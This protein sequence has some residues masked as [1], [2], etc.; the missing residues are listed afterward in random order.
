[1]S[2]LFNSI[3]NDA[4]ATASP[5]QLML[6][7]LVSLILRLGSNLDLQIPNPIHPRICR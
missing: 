7:L 6:A 5:L 2:N 3:F 1:M 4:T